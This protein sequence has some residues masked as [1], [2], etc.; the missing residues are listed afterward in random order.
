[1][2]EHHTLWALHPAVRL[3]C[4]ALAALAWAGLLALLA[5]L[6]LANDPP[7]TVDLL[8][9]GFLFLVVVPHVCLRLSLRGFAGTARILNGKLRV[10]RPGRSVE[11]QCASIAG[12]QPWRIPLP[13]PGLTLQLASGARFP[14]RLAL[15]DPVPLLEDLARAGVR[16]AQ[17]ALGTS[18]VRY[19]NARAA[20]TRRFFD[21]AWC[22]VVLYS[23]L[24]AAIGFNAH[25]HIAFGAFLGE[26]Y[27]MGLG[28]WLRT[29]AEYWLTALLYLAMWAGLFRIAVEG[30]SLAAAGFKSERAG[31]ARRLAERAATLLY[32]LSVPALLAVRFLG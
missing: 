20:W 30:F 3:L 4:I 18:A 22:K 24:P 21:S 19:A 11:V 10:D 2:L 23:L 17:S 14:D 16:S 15:R 13:Q 9:R 8:S 12:I 25:Q 32:Y 5:L 7:L 1:V 28:A 27:L 29:A 26:Y 31:G 6:L